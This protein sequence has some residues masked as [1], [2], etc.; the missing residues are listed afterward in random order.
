WLVRNQTYEPMT[1]GG[2]K[3]AWPMWAGDGR[4]LFFMSDRSGAQNIWSAPAAAP[5]GATKAITTFSDGRGLWPSGKLDGRTIAFERN[6]AIWTVDT[7]S[8]QAREVPIALRGA[9][10]A[11]AVE[12]R[13]FT[14]Q[15]RELAM[16][17]DGK[18]IAFV[19]HGE[20]FS[21]SAR[22]GGDA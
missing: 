2:A 15:I 10:A 13:T 3:D 11:A 8:G 17:P 7:A 5:G 20:I 22:D 12:H 16:S 21:A 6:F 19:V 9:P 14:D 1:R 4:T 18:K